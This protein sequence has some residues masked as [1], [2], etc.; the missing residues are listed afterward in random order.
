MMIIVFHQSSDNKKFI[1]PVQR[2]R[3]IQENDNG[4]ATIHTDI[5]TNNPDKKKTYRTKESVNQLAESA[6]VYSNPP[7]GIF[8]AF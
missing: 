4:G 7:S 2:I 1:L 5:N 8:S 3:F 6:K